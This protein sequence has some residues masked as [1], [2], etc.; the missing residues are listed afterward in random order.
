MYHI[1][2]Y[3]TWNINSLSMTG[4]PVSEKVDVHED[5][6]DSKVELPH[7]TEA[8]VWELSYF[9]NAQNNWM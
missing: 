1:V 3:V 9:C 6:S 5:H 7:F 2:Y 4:V 8:Q